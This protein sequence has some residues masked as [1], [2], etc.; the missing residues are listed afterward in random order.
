[1]IISVSRRSDIPAFYGKWFMNRIRAGY[2]IVPNPFKPTQVS[3]V[4]LVPEAVE[5]IVFWTRNPRPLFPY[6]TE[7]KERGYDY[8][9]QYTVMNNPGILDPR[10]PSVQV[11]LKT[12][13]ELSDRIGSQRMIWRYD[14]IVFSTVTPPEFHRNNFSHIARR[15]RGSTC[16]CVVSILDVY[17]KVKRR[18][19]QLKKHGVELVACEDEV[20]GD[21]MNTFA[22]AAGENGMEIVSCAEEIDLRPFGIQPG[23]CIDGEYISHILGINV[24]SKKDP[25]QRKACGC[26][27]SKDIGMYDTCLFGCQYCY[28]TTSHERAKINHEK[29]EPNSPSLTGQN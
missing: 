2:C 7:L 29:H 17:R 21:L 8:L 10:C 4:S 15:L 16:R 22:R 12:F 14:P 26:V 5:V 24:S 18:F 13:R 20:F 6:L 23:K 9:F 1:M 3:R 25:S 11:S 27:L 28:A 19:R